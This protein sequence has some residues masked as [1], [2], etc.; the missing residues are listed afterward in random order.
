MFGKSKDRTTP[1][2]SFAL[3]AWAS[4]TCIALAVAHMQALEVIFLLSK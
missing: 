2:E 3:N 1:V 4:M